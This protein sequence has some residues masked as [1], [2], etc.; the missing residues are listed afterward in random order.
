MPTLKPPKQ[1][2]GLQHLPSPLRRLTEMVFPQEPEMPTPAIVKMPGAKQAG[3][4]VLERIRT[5]PTLSG[6]GHN[7]VTALTMLQQKYPRMFGH[8]LDV[9]EDTGKDVPATKMRLGY[10]ESI[11]PFS[12]L[13]L[14]S[15]HNLDDTLSTAAHE[16]THAAQ[17]LRQ[18]KMFTPKYNLYNKLVGYKH[19]PFEQ[20]ANKAGANFVQRVRNPKIM[21]P[22]K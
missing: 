10:Q 19:N 5:L 6:Y 15:G 7:A 13:A 20:R 9:V 11:G 17:N 8:V 22:V 3:L 18:P 21:E 12:K 4:K 16:L 1:F 14:A 2:P